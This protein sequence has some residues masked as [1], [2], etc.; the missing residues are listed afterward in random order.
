M[1]IFYVR[2]VDIFALSSQR[3]YGTNIQLLAVT[4]Y[5]TQSIK[6]LCQSGINFLGKICSISTGKI[7]FN[8]AH[9]SDMMIGLPLPWRPDAVIYTMLL[10]CRNIQFWFQWLSIFA[11]QCHSEVLVL[12]SINQY[13][14][15]AT[16]AAY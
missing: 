10:P 6:S 1:P 13:S 4:E 11:M 9:V 12:T 5:N 15:L 7:N 2:K 16:D 14:S 8:Q 3:T